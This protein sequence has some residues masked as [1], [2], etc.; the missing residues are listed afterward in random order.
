MYKSYDY[1]NRHDIYNID[2]IDDNIVE[3]ITVKRIYQLK[4]VVIEKC[5]NLKKIVIV[6]CKDSIYLGEGL[7]NLEE[8]YIESC[9][10]VKIETYLKDKIKKINFASIN[11]LHFTF[12]NNFPNIVSF[13]CN[14]CNFQTTLNIYNNCLTRLVLIKCSIKSL[15]LN[16]DMNDLKYLHL[17]E[18]DMKQ[19]YIKDPLI[20]IDYINLSKNKLKNPHIIIK[21]IIKRTSYNVLELHI[22]EDMVINDNLKQYIFNN[23]EMVNITIY[24]QNL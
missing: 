7:L 20:R 8:L 10:N 23:K 4:S 3:N 18:N 13:N 11:I 16:H 6:G 21:D 19:L 2:F 24:K 14:E 15:F 9:P 1:Y 22:D 12:K 17:K 5:I